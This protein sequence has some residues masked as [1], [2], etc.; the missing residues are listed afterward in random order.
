MPARRLQCLC[1][2]LAWSAVTTSDLGAAAA[3]EPPSLSSLAPWGARAAAQAF[4][5]L[6]CFEDTGGGEPPRPRR[7]PSRFGSLSELLRLAVT[8]FLAL[9]R[10][11]LTEAPAAWALDGA[12][13][14][15][16]L[17]ETIDAAGA[18]SSSGRPAHFVQR[19][20]LPRGATVATFGDLHGSY[21]SLLRSLGELAE[22]GFLDPETFAVAPAHARDFFLLFLGDYVDRGAYGAEVVAALLQL[23][24]SSPSNVYLIRGNHED[25]LMNGES[26]GGTFLDEL[27]SKFPE[28]TAEDLR[29]VF[30]VYE[31]LPVAIFLGVAEGDDGTPPGD[32]AE[33]PVSRGRDFLLA[34]HGGLEVG[35]DAKPLLRAPV[36]DGD[37]APSGAVSHFA[38]LHGLMRRRWWDELP[39]G[40]REKVQRGAGKEL[41]SN[42]GSC[43]RRRLVD[44]GRGLL[45]VAESSA[46]GRD[47]GW[48]LAP[49]EMRPHLGFMWNDFYT[50]DETKEG[51]RQSE[52]IYFRPGR[53]FGFGREVTEHGLRTAG[54]VGVL[55]AH[56]HNDAAETGPM[57]SSLKA[58]T[59]PG[60]FDTFDRAGLVVTFLSGAFIPGQGFA[61]D[62][63][64]LLRLRGVA[65]SSWAIDVCAN[66]AAGGAPASLERERR[67]ATHQA[68]RL[69]S[70]ALNFSCADSGWR[71]AP[72]PADRGAPWSA[73][74]DDSGVGGGRGEL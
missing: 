7:M 27:L 14:A 26:T 64:G 67:L 6:P 21:H 33:P 9:Q 74:S 32:A 19:L 45:E 10:A 13:G 58:A 42:L 25:V 63:F 46:W 2:L 49:T 72:P 40:L 15:D 17:R 54:F 43:P 16:R 52:S 24:L 51:A 73:C 62:A 47:Q 68:D 39:G 31:T 23:K 5:L 1:A 48:P 53:G 50:W 3:T 35:Y 30:R 59:P 44:G 69:C 20:L 11:H 66:A 37:A 22:K 61:F 71:A 56:Q 4:A 60:A 70:A 8:P 28:A 65:A 38:L 55:R 57:L 18:A 41:F 29:P 36:G 34:C 12:F